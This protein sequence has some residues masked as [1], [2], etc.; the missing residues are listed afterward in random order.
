M[1][2]KRRRLR[3]VEPQSEA[4]GWRDL[5]QARQEFVTHAEVDRRFADQ[6]REVVAA[7]TTIDERLGR[8][9]EFRDQLE[10]ERNEYATKIMMETEAKDLRHEIELLRTEVRTL[11]DLRQV[12]Q[13]RDQWR[14]GVIVTAGVA[15]ASAAVKY[16]IPGK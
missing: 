15:M 14:L 5:Y 6:Q 12:A 3:L 4:V 10:R 8:M 11:Q 1:S 16:L 9:N 7:R 13:G 2:D